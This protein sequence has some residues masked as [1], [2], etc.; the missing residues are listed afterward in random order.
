MLLGHKMVTCLLTSM[1]DSNF[2]FYSVQYSNLQTFDQ[3]GQIRGTPQLLPAVLHRFS[4][5]LILLVITVSHQRAIAIK[6][7]TQFF[8]FIVPI[9]SLN[10]T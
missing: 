9:R 7:E 5:S 3:L 10:S 1:V 2:G 6:F 8:L 4:L